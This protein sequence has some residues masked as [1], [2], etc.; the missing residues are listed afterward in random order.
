MHHWAAKTDLMMHLF[1]SIY[2]GAIK[3]AS[4]GTIINTNDAFYCIDTKIIICN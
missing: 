2:I 1:Y 3:N 4:L